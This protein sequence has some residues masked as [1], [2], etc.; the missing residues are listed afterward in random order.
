MEKLR[1]QYEKE[2]VPAMMK[3]FNYSSV[4]QVPKLDKIVINIGLGDTKDNPKALDNAM[5][6]LSIITGQKP[7]VTKARKSIAAFKLR[8]GANVGCKVTLRSTKMYEFAYKLFKNSSEYS[9]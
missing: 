6:D 1:E 9:L 8:E 4:M 7:I 3:K 2:V 5:N